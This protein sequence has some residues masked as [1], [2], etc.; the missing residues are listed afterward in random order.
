MPGRPGSPRHATCLF[1]ASDGSSIGDRNIAPRRRLPRSPR[2]AARVGARGPRPVEGSSPHAMRRSPGSCS[3]HGER[4][5]PARG[6]IIAREDDGEPRA[7]RAAAA[8]SRGSRR[9]YRRR[10]RCGRRRPATGRGD[11]SSTS[12]VPSRISCRSSSHHRAVCPAKAG[13]DRLSPCV[14]RACVGAPDVERY[15][16]EPSRAAALDAAAGRGPPGSPSRPR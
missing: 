3:R 13:A 4:R 9:A 8:T 12:I 10:T 5:R 6:A 7:C 11:P 16:A 1:L 14:E 2:G 15:A